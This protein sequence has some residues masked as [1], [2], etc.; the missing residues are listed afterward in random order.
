MNHESCFIKASLGWILCSVSFWGHARVSCMKITCFPIL[1]SFVFGLSGRVLVRL[2]RSDAL[3]DHLSWGNNSDNLQS[4]QKWVVF[5]I[6]CVYR[7][8]IWASIARYPPSPPTPWL[9]VCIVAPQYPSPPVVWVVVGGGGGGRSCMCM[10][11]NVYVWCECMF[12][13]FVY[14]YDMICIW[15]CMCICYY[16]VLRSYY[17]VLRSTT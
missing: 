12:L 9:W 10:Y 17:V 14:D 11:M 13:V 16:V 8:Y 1:I 6:Q 2:P 5:Y 15:I 4:K 3:K 7:V